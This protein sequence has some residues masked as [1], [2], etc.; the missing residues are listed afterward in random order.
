MT[1]SD[2]KI[3]IGDSWKSLDEIKININDSWKDVDEAYINVGD[4][5]KQFYNNNQNLGNL[6]IDGESV[7]EDETGTHT[8]TTHGN[9]YIES[10]QHTCGDGSVKFDGD[11]DYLTTPNH[12]DFDFSNDDFTI[13]TWVRFNNEGGVEVIAGQWLLANST[14]NSWCVW[15]NASDNIYFI[16]YNSSSQ[17][18]IYINST[19]A[20]LKYGWYHIAVVRNGAS[21][22]LYINGVS[23]GTNVG[24]NGVIT[25]STLPLMIGNYWNETATGPT[26]YDLDGYID[27]FRITKGSALWTSNFNLTNIELLYSSNTL[28]YSGDLFID[29]ESV[30]EDETGNH[31]LT[32]NGATSVTTSQHCPQGGSTSSIYF[33]GNNDYITSP[34]DG[35][36]RLRELDFTIDLW[37]RFAPDNFSSTQRIMAQ[38]ENSGGTDRSWRLDKSQTNEIR[39]KARNAAGT[40]FVVLES[41]AIEYDIWYHIAVVRKGSDWTLYINGSFEDAA[42]VSD[43]IVNSSVPLMI[44]D[45]WNVGA[46]GNNNTEFN[47]WMDLIRLKRRQALWTSEFD[48]SSDSELLYPLGYY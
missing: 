25:N 9:T 16:A 6:F 18:V 10:V 32:L 19:T 29:G 47:G 4:S 38:Y 42:D 43:E 7:I 39:F 14:L 33:D 31:T 41:M 27:N 1:N 22:K 8:I 35:D 46:T 13:D 23:E 40:E 28:N 21:S 3:N 44:G 34:D 5:W 24:N 15:K 12:T 2:N 36:W 17:Q 45:Y 37:V 26:V 20:L 30:I 11:G 48:S